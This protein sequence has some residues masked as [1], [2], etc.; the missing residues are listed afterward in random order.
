MGPQSKE[1]VCDALGYL[2]EAVARVEGTLGR[3]ER[4]LQQRAE[5][6]NAGLVQVNRRV[7]ELERWRR[8]G[9]GGNGAPAPAE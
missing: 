3:I 7:T 8:T 4:L 2:I 5:Q 1:A 9:G 6:E